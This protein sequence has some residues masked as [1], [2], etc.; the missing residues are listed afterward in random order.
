MSKL[1]VSWK[2]S[3][4]KNNFL[5]KDKHPDIMVSYLI[6][7]KSEMDNNPSILDKSEL[8]SVIKLVTNHGVKSPVDV[9]IHFS[10]AYGNKIDLYHSL[11]GNKNSLN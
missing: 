2:Q 4:F 1:S 11:P 3:A 9:D 5:L 8:Q 6:Y 7:I 10:T